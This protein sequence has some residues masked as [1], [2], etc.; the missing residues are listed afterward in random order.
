MPESQR[1]QYLRHALLYLERAAENAT[2]ALN[3]GRL[4]EFRG[5]LAAQQAYERSAAL[6]RAFLTALIDNKPVVIPGE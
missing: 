4:D 2:W 6:A 5:A 3:Q 1:E